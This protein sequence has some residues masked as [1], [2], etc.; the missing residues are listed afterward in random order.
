MIGH[1]VVLRPRSISETGDLAAAFVREHRRQY[2]KLLPWVLVPAVLA[3]ALHAFAGFAA[4]EA[5]AAE[6]AISGIGAGVYTLLCGELMLRSDVSLRE[7]QL[8]FLRALPGFLLKRLASWCVLSFTILLGYG[9]V[10]FVPEGALLERGTLGATMSRSAA[11]F[12]AV[13]GR[14]VM[15]GAVTLGL[16]AAGAMSA[17]FVWHAVRSLVGFG[18]S[19]ARVFSE[20]WSWAPFLGIALVQPYLATM[21]FLLYIDCRTRREGWDLQVQM[22][23]LVQA[24]EARRDARTSST[25]VA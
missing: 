13:P 5:V 15:W 20:N 7:L 16:L 1:R 3:W 10:A 4:D 6:L 14:I 18:E 11:L 22:S 19:Q 21:R 9:W 12:R 2:V 23:A 24:A 25:E 17:D 8:R